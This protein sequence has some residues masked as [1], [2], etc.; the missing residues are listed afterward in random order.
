MEDCGEAA[1]S[2]EEL[3]PGLEALAPANVPRKAPSGPSHAAAL[4]VHKPTVLVRGL[5]AGILSTDML[6][7]VLE[8]A[9]LD[10][11]LVTYSSTPGSRV[12]EA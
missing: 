3:P 5:P 6:E 8:Q 11:D 12:G 4:K 1:D 2:L 10:S 7:A 9:D